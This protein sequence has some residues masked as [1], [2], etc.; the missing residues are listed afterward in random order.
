M[1]YDVKIRVED[2]AIS[3]CRQEEPKVHVT[4]MLTSPEMRNVS[5]ED[6]AGMWLAFDRFFDGLCSAETTQ[7]RKHMRESRIPLSQHT[8]TVMWARKVE[9]FIT[10]VLLCVRG[11][12]LHLIWLE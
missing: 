7:S 11:P 10:I 4:V 12:A 5:D 2:A 6:A 8:C 1:K 3:V 9:H